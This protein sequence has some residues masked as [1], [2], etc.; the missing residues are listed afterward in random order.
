MVTAL[1]ETTLWL[2]R[3]GET[4]WNV[5]R[6]FQGQ[7]DIPLNHTGF[8]QAK[9]LAN[10]LSNDHQSFK[11]AALYTSDLSRARDTAAPIAAALNLAAIED[12]HLRERHYGVLSALT[13]EEMAAQHPEAFANWKARNPDYVIAEGES[14]R[15]FHERIVAR[16]SAIAANHPG[17]HV[18]VVAHGGVLD[19]AYRAG[20]GMD[21]SL[22]RQHNLLNAS[23]NRVRV[24]AGKMSV[25][26]WGD[27][28]HLDEEAFDEM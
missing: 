27:V 22:P 6:R 14:L 1:S 10:R 21:L 19:C 28:A 5:E 13:P 7:I 15:N 8:E 17:A 4:A 18:L 24:R 9:M 2:I 16:L 23:L 26:C 12:P 11:F 25:A 20:T 3:H